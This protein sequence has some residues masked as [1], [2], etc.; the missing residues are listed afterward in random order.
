[1]A[2]A[3]HQALGELRV[4]VSAH[5]NQVCIEIAGTFGKALAHGPAEVQPLLAATLGRRM[6]ALPE[7]HRRLLAD[8]AA[9]IAAGV[10]PVNR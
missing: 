3:A 2:G 4:P 7:G 1:M 8:L 9:E 5:D 6:A 10:A